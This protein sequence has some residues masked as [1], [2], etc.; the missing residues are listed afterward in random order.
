M[1][2]FEPGL[3]AAEADAALRES[4]REF[5]RVEGHLVLWFD[6]M[7]RRRAFQDLG[8]GSI[9]AYA[10]GRLG[11]SR[12]KTGQLVRLSRVLD[13]LPALRGALAQGDLTWTKARVIARVALPSTEAAWIRIAKTAGRRELELRARAARTGAR[14]ARSSQTGLTLA[15]HPAPTT[16][17][18]GVRAHGAGSGSPP[19]LRGDSSVGE[20]EVPVHARRE[21]GSGTARCA[22]ASAPGRGSGTS[23]EGRDPGAADPSAAPDVSG[24]ITTDL[25]PLDVEVPVQVSLR[26]TPEQYARFE[27][28][29]EAARKR[30]IHGSREELVLGGMEAAI[31][32][33]REMET[34]AGH[35]AG[36]AGGNAS[37]Q[38]GPE[39]GSGI[40]TRV[41]TG[42]GPVERAGT[43][44]PWAGESAP[45]PAGKSGRNRRATVGGPSG[46][47]PPAL[48][49][50]EAPPV[51]RRALAPFYQVVVSQC[52]TCG[53]GRV[54]TGRG[55]RA[56]STATLKAVLCDARVH[57]KGE[58]N[59][60][61]IPP[62]VRSAV[63]ERDGFR[64]RLP[65]CRRTR[66]LQIH[67]VV[68]R[69]AGGD[70]RVE[71]LVALCSGCH[72]ALHRG[73]DLRLASLLKAR[74]GRGGRGGERRRGGGVGDEGN[75]QG[76]A[77][78]AGGPAHKQEE[79]ATAG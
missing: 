72:H 73:G 66:F 57:R 69:E 42:G 3:S 40:G 20:G 9:Y 12:A 67:H 6:D 5:R 64:C 7:F 33:S 32:M 71:N 50:A 63:L 8:F 2:A 68:P 77:P 47:M 30:G 29:L 61:T 43:G 17:F 1:P 22:G 38:A 41:P 27:A 45:G 26:F 49:A 78:S 53:R 59:R 54:V 23:R 15:G 60:A 19:P 62:S 70:N 39:R 37:T 79:A 55:D 31:S 48:P 51:D 58:R 4:I 52:D 21:A 34:S 46:T 13:G 28:L 76:S 18:P 25:S 75:G 10:A 65:G 74:G 44:A 14:R 36:G 56:L 11:F 24:D 35:L 16:D